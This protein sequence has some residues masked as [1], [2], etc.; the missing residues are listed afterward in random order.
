M[1]KVLPSLVIAFIV[2]GGGGIIPTSSKDQPSEWLV[3]SREGSLIHAELSGIEQ[4]IVPSAEQARFAGTSVSDEGRWVYYLA[5][6][7]RPP[8]L[9]KY[10]LETV[11]EAHS[12][13]VL[14]ADD[15]LEFLGSSAPSDST[16][17]VTFHSATWL[18]DSRGFQIEGGREGGGFRAVVALVGDQWQLG[19]LPA[20]WDWLPEENLSFWAQGGPNPPVIYHV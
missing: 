15:V 18:P 1:K 3:V 7:R 11:E 19:A 4:E 13:I 9:W 17:S 6:S 16:G 20:G 10:N 8:T 2:A 5:T 12:T 14:T